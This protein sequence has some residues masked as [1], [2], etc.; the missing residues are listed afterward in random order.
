LVVAD[1]GRGIDPEAPVHVGHGLKNLR[2]RAESLGGS[3]EV[4]SP[5]QGGMRLAWRARL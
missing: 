5:S 2:M 4:E 3:L 1:N